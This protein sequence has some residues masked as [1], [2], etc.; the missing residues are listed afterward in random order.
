MLRET[1][2]WIIEPPSSRKKISAWGCPTSLG[3]PWVSLVCWRPPTPTGTGWTEHLDGQGRRRPGDSNPRSFFT[4]KQRGPAGQ[5]L[6][7]DFRAVTLHL[8]SEAGCGLG[9]PQASNF[10]SLKGPWAGV[11]G[12]PGPASPAILGEGPQGL[13]KYPFPPGVC[14]LVLSNQPVGVRV[15]AECGRREGQGSPEES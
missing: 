13:E 12:T 6:H 9:R 11:T 1:S 3:F 7:P 10:R 8:G 2:G 15:W 14:R 5:F 4:L